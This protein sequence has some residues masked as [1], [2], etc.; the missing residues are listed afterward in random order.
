MASAGNVRGREIPSPRPTPYGVLCAILY[1]GLPPVGF[2]LLLD[3]AL[4][5]VFTRLLGRCYGV[6]CLLG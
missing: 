1:V 2:L 4:Y 3:A 6:F 5:L